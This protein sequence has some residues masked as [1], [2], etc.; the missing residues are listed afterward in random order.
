MS[1]LSFKT[2]MEFTYGEARELAPGVVRIVANNPSVF[3]FKGTNTYVVGMDELCVIDPGP[4]DDAHFE[5][6]MAYAGDRTISTVAITHTHRDHIDGL[7]RLVAATG[8]KVCGYGRTAENK[9]AAGAHP[10]T[11]E[12]IEESFVPDQA[13]ADLRQGVDTGGAVHPGPRA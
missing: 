2:D 3:T 11:S 12:Y 9:G 6:I 4:E 7:K 13:L 1:E 8:A 5:A 10:R